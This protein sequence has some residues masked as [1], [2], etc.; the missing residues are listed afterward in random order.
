MGLLNLLNKLYV[1]YAAHDYFRVVQQITLIKKFIFYAGSP[2]LYRFRQLGGQNSALHM[3]AGKRAASHRVQVK[4]SR[5]SVYEGALGGPRTGLD[6]LPPPPPS[7][8]DFWPG[9]ASAAG[10]PPIMGSFASPCSP[11]MSPPS[12][13][14]PSAAAG[15]APDLAFP[16][17]AGFSGAAGL[18]MFCRKPP[19]D[20]VMGFAAFTSSLDGSFGGGGEG[21]G[22]RRGK[23]RDGEGRRGGPHHHTVLNAHTG[24][25]LCGPPPWPS[26]PPTLPL[27]LTTTTPAVLMNDARWLALSSSLKPYSSCL[28][29]CKKAEDGGGGGTVRS[30]RPLPW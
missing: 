27:T 12:G 4:S 11:C 29:A 2:H 26:P 10:C 22:G 14:L 15:A 24:G 25:L 16:P 19:M 28:A 20:S 13:L 17:A 3:C 1:C 5:E 9:L 21:R 30:T 18:P 7:P 23:A 8:Y 6:L